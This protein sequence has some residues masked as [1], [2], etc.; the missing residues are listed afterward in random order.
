MMNGAVTIGT[1]DGANIEIEEAVGRENIIIFGLNAQQALGYYSQ[2]GYNAWEIYNEDMRVKTVLE[3]LVNG[4]LPDEKEEF[5]TLYDYLLRNNDEFFVLKDF[6]A[7]A[8]AQQ[9]LDGKFRQHDQWLSMCLKNI[10]H[11]GIFSSDRTVGEYSRE[12][13]NLQSTTIR[14]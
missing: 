12:I 8:E 4:Y 5:R 10:A 11:S 14:S 9:L 3:Q 6:A 7:Y 13:W 1:L 2:G